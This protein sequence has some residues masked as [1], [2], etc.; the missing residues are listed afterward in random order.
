[1]VHV[2]VKR[3]QHAV[4]HGGFHVGNI[5]VRY[6]AARGIETPAPPT[7]FWYVYDCGSEQGSSLS[8]SLAAHRERCHGRTDVLFVSHL[9][10]D[11][12]N[13]IERLQA[14]APA[15][16]VFVPY[17]EPV[18]LL[19]VA[20]A[21]VEAGRFSTSFREYVEDPAAWW[22]RRGATRII[23]IEPDDGDSSLLPG[24]DG[25]EGPRSPDDFDA[26][27]RLRSEGDGKK[28]PGAR[29]ASYLVPP[30]GVVPSGLFAADPSVRSPVKGDFL[31]GNGSGM[32]LEHTE[33]SYSWRV[34]DWILLP[35]VHPVDTKTREQFRR[36][37]SEA[38]GIP[39]RPD[40][41]TKRMLEH[42]Q[43]YEKTKILLE[44]YRNHFARGQNALS[45]SLYSGPE[46]RDASGASAEWKIDWWHCVPFPPRWIREVDVGWLGA[47]D[48]ELRRPAIRASWLQFFRPFSSQIAVLTLPHHGFAHN[49]DPGILGCGDLSVAL[50]TTVERIARV[51][52]MRETLE[53]V[54][55]AGIAAHV[56]D[57]R[58]DS[59]FRIECSR[60]V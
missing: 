19:V 32:R 52:R 26:D 23:F 1:V 3:V 25:S 54:E 36:D 34:G 43:S 22:R 29:L 50:A 8:S 15:E 12:I 46:H 49:F 24:P 53:A 10:S 21:D 7:D 27:T 18:D 39:H 57:D 16:T 2:K 28:R 40:V 35:Y 5:H 58:R 37:M 42:L 33:V 51:A 48:A 17:L 14:M 11:H 13:G 30:R 9:H 31:A 6:P 59:R 60:T 45:M 55:D 41:F 44:V 47:G 38:L 56:V 4:G 20:L